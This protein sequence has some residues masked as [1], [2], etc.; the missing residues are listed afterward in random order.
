MWDRL[1]VSSDGLPV[2]CG[3]RPQPSSPRRLPLGP[4]WPK[5]SARSPHA[6]DFGN[7]SA[8]EQDRPKRSTS[9]SRAKTSRLLR[10]IFDGR[11]KTGHRDLKVVEM[12]VRPAMHQTGATALT[13][14]PRFAAHSAAADWFTEPLG[15]C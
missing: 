7:A 6:G 9:K 14:L 15:D 3:A 8:Q 5:P 11:R 12:L 1:R 13:E 4:A 10:V 2:F